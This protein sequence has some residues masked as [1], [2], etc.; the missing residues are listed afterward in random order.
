MTGAPTLPLSSQHKSSPSVRIFVSPLCAKSVVPAVAG[1][2]S[3]DPKRS[4]AFR[5]T[6]SEKQP[7]A[8]RRLQ[9]I[10]RE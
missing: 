5:S 6:R 3:L 8:D 10:A 1:N 2:G 7:D 4:F 9:M